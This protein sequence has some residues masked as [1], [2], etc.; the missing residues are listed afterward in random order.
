MAGQSGTMRPLPGTDVVGRGIYLRPYQPYVLKNVLFNQGEMKTYFS[1]ETGQTFSVPACYAINESPPMP[2]NRMINQTVIEESFERFDKQFGLDASVAGGVQGF[3][4]DAQATQSKHLRS[5]EDAYYA[6][7]CSFIPLWSIYMSDLK[8]LLETQS[9][10]AV[11]DL[12]EFLDFL[13][14]GM[15]FDHADRFRYEQFFSRFGTHYV[16]R[17]WVGGKANL[18]FI[19]AKSSNMTKADIQTGI[20][21]SIGGLGSGQVSVSS[22]QEKENLQKNSECQILGK[23]GDE[24]KLALLSSLDESVYNEWIA[25][26]TNNPQVIELDVIG[27]WTLFRD[28]DIAR[29]LQQAYQAETT[30]HQVSSIFALDEKIYVVRGKQYFCHDLKSHTSQTPRDLTEGWPELASIGFERI[31]SAIVGRGL[32]TPGGDDLSRKLFFFKEGRYVR[33]DADSGKVDPGYPKPISEGWPGVAFDRIDAA[34]NCGDDAVYFFCGKA[35]TRFNMRNNRVDAGYPDLI[36]SR[37]AGLTFDRIDAAIY[38]ANGKVYFFREDQYILYDMTIYRADPGY[39]KFV[40]GEY[41]EDWDF[42]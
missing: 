7:R 12:K 14:P 5:E 9:E 24:L 36:N 4:I 29:A 34:I 33:M 38:W 30:F 31:D 10:V 37:W 21:A 11:E 16:R 1:K 28:P 3:S 41:I 26:I 32:S 27:I 15:T 13:K 6:L 39:P 20:K 40:V 19:V 2:S 22:Q 42:F 25:T 23:G 18:A 17:A 8:N 35:Y